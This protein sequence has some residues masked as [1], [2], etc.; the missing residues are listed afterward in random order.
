MEK[1]ISDKL[2][3]VQAKLKAPKGQFNSFAKFAYRSCEDILEAVKPLLAESGLALVMR[4]SIELI[5]DRY[6]VKATAIINGGEASTAYAREPDIKK[7]MDASQITGMASSYARKYALN[8]LFLIDD[9]KDADSMDNSKSEPPAKKPT[10][11]KKE[12]PKE[13]VDLNPGL[14]AWDIWKTPKGSTLGSIVGNPDLDS[15]TKINGLTTLLSNCEKLASKAK[16][17]S[18]AAWRE[19]D[20]E[21]VK[22]ALEEVEM[23]AGE[24]KPKTDEPK[25]EDPF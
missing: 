18:E 22:K 19:R 14:P 12:S 21:L 9:T 3:Q 1:E 16:D 4:D 10:P 8:A 17:N 24:P 15:E 13:A 5:G 25:S 23:F 2:L 11:K 20:V 6:Y 7:G